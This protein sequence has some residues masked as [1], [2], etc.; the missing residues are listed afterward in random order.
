MGCDERIDVENV[1][2]LCNNLRPYAVD[3]G[4][5]DPN[6]LTAFGRDYKPPVAT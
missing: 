5:G 2:R 3:H 6:A 4:N 1:D